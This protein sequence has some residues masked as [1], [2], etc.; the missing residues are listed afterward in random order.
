M[1]NIAG[2]LP[3][4]LGVGQGQQAQGGGGTQLVTMLVTFGLMIYRPVLGVVIGR[5]AK[6]WGR[7][8]VTWGLL[9]GFLSPVLFAII[10]AIAGRKK[11]TSTSSII[12]DLDQDRRTSLEARFKAMGL[13]MGSGIRMVIYKWLD[14]QPR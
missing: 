2:F 7:D 3:L 9:A 4:M 12:L 1:T 14:D 5:W 10:L 8:G 6:R 11:G 13:D